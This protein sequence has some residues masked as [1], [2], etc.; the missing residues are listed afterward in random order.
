[1][2]SANLKFSFVFPPH[3]H[4]LCFYQKSQKKLCRSPAN[5]LWTSKAERKSQISGCGRLRRA[6]RAAG[7]GWSLSTGTVRKK[8]ESRKKSKN[9]KWEVK[10]AVVCFEPTWLI[11]PGGEILVWQLKEADLSV[12]KDRGAFTSIRGGKGGFG[13]CFLASEPSWI[14]DSDD[15]L[16]TFF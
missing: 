14:N 3:P 1:M 2:G 13:I 11:A 6:V 8:K 9:R 15:N 5:W 16:E 4:R 7:P 10:A 12:M